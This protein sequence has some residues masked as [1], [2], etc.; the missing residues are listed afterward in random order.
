M[1]K[2]S[3]LALSALFVTGMILSACS[4]GAGLADANSQSGSLERPEPPE[5]F[6]DRTNPLDEDAAAIGEGEILYQAN[7]ASCHGA[8]GLGDGP[9][10]AAL[11]P[12]PQNLAENQS[13]LTDAYVYWRIAEG[14]MIAPF[15]SVMPAWRGI[16]AEEQIWQ[17][18][19]YL[20][21]LSSQN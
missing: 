2:S 16:L 15:N 9:A 21:T 5:D 19:A 11:E 12:K 10:A 8:T 20:R 18:V 17:I 3:R 6:A 4:S 13:S 14:G 1:K 7:C